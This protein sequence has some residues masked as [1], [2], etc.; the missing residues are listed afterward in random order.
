MGMCALCP[1]CEIDSVL[2]DASGY[3]ITHD[4]LSKMR[5]YWFDS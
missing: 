1:R 5:H 2:G 4:F 3:P